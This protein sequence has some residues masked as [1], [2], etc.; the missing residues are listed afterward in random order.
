MWDGVKRFPTWYSIISRPKGLSKGAQGL[1]RLDQ[2]WKGGSKNTGPSGIHALVRKV[3]V[4]REDSISPVWMYSSSKGVKWSASHSVVPGALRPHGLYS[5]WNSP[6]QNTGS[7]LQGISQ[8]RD[9]TPVSWI[10]DGFFTSWATGEAQRILEWVA[11]LCSSRSSQPRNRTGVSCIAGRFF[12]KFSYEGS[13]EE[14]WRATKL[15]R[16][17]TEDENWE[18]LQKPVLK[19]TSMTLRELENSGLLRRRAQRS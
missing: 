15:R 17:E 1:E 4:H 14:P 18:M 9:Q 10:A 19:K 6:G 12:T 5:P 16:R 2:P 8:P 13:Y 3:I 7:L 11:Y